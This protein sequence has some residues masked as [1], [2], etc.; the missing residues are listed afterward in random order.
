M[1]HGSFQ[2]LG[3]IEAARPVFLMVMGVFLMLIAW[4]LAQT[5]G[6]WTSRVLVSGALLLGIGYAVIL[7]LY[8]AGLV[9]PYSPKGH[10][11]GNGATAVA[12]HAVK[13]VMM[14]LGWLMFG[15]GVVLHANVFRSS[16]PLTQP[17]NRTLSPHESVA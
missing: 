6:V 4:R 11:H 16:S 13:L 14:N 8:H 7:P 2:T 1:S 10:Y 9:E 12:W 3:S 17:Q 5:S 15:L